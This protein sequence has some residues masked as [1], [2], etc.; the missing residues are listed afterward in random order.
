MSKHKFGERV[1]GKPGK[2]VLIEGLFGKWK[3]SKKLFNYEEDGIA[4]ELLKTKIKIDGV[5]TRDV[6]E[7]KIGLIENYNCEAVS[8]KHTVRCFMEKVHYAN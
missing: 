1:F 6:A 5:F 4:I 8:K 2:I 7:T 3:I